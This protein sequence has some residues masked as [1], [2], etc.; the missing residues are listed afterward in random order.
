[1]KKEIE[2]LNKVIKYLGEKIE[3]AKL[4]DIL[5]KDKNKESLI[6]SVDCYKRALFFLEKAVLYEAKNGAEL[7]CDTKAINEIE[8]DIEKL[9]QKAKELFE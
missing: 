1:M 2:K 9:N 4:I 6:I 5:I 3:K 7:K 8:K